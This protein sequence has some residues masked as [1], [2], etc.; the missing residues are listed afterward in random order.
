[1]RLTVCTPLVRSWFACAQSALLVACGWTESGTS[2]VSLA[3]DATF[4]T[5]FTSGRLA[6]QEWLSCREIDTTGLIPRSQCGGVHAPGTP[7]F[8]AYSRA[9][10]A[11]RRVAAVDSSAPTLHATA[12]IRLRAARG[13]RA[14]LDRAVEALEQ[15]RIRMP[16]DKAILNDLA[17][18]YEAVAERDQAIMPMLRALDAVDAALARDST[19]APARFNR[20]L[21]L[22]RLFLVRT[23]AP[24]W[25]AYIA[26]ERDERW[27]T[28]ARA[29]V[30]AVWQSQDS[31]AP[32]LFVQRARGRFFSLLGSWGAT[33]GRGD[34]SRGDRTLAEMVAL[35]DSLG[36][37][38]ADQSVAMTVDWLHAQLS[39]RVV[40]RRIAP[41]FVDLANGID[42]HDSS[43]YD[44]C[45]A[46]LGRA[47]AALRTMN[48][49]AARWAAVY[50]A[51]C[52]ANQRRF[53]AAADTRLE[54]ALA[55]ATAREPALIGKAL[56]LRGVIQMRRGNYETASQLYAEARS[57][58]ARAGDTFNEA[59]VS[60]LLTENLA[61]AGQSLGSEVEAYKG[62]GGL[63]PFRASRYLKNLLIQ[64][65]A[66]A[67]G[68]RLRAA[69][70]DVL[71]E[72]VIVDRALR[73]PGATAY[74]R[75]TRAEDLA[76]VGDTAKALADLDTAAAAA[77]LVPDTANRM[78]ATA[79][80]Q[81]ARARLI[82]FSNPRLTRR[83]VNQAVD[84][85]RAI[86][87]VNVLPAALFQSALL[88]NAQ[89]QGE[90]ARADLADAISVIEHA[91]EAFTSA[92][93]QAAYYETVEN[94]F[95]LAIQCELRDG[96]TDA[97]FDL[98]ERE[99]VAIRREA[100]SRGVGT[101][102]S[103]ASLSE[104]IPHDMLFVTY[105]VLADR[106]AIW[107]A[108]HG[109][110]GYRASM[111]ARDSVA[112]L[113]RRAVGEIRGS[114]TL[115][116]RTRLFEILLQP[117]TEELRGAHVIAAVP[118][119]ELVA[120]PLAALW[121]PVTKRYVVEDVALITEPS[122]SFM[123]AASR[124]S[125]SRPATL[126]ALV[127]GNPAHPSSSD[128]TLADLP[129]AAAEA[130]QVAD[131][132][133]RRKVLTGR[134]AT[135]RSVID[136]LSR[137]N[138]FHFAGHAV[139]DPGHPERSY[140]A[141]SDSGRARNGRLEAREIAH[142]SLSNTEIVVLSACRTLPAKPSRSGAV[143]GIAFSFLRAGAP[144][145]V[146]TLWDVADDGTADV[147][148]PLH[149]ALRD[150]VEPPEAL[151][152]AQVA[153]MKSTDRPGSPAGTWAAFVY[154]GPWT[155]KGRSR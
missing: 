34:R 73:A 144:A 101:S 17:V 97:A 15:A 49:P 105:A 121:N 71:S 90:R 100:R 70:L 88:A 150:G 52:E 18:A 91:R 63:A 92:Q 136:E 24:A 61:F 113:A 9:A 47:E 37:K 42:L 16:T 67:R 26:S 75:W 142:L 130:S 78:R 146:S 119:R 99:R 21:I 27:K 29:H 114:G 143:A 102:V 56:W 84:S 41:A 72:A 81:L 148:V 89:G 110:R 39:N 2:L 151:R 98:L 152:R 50:R 107:Y 106:V 30:Q 139:F 93:A 126:S 123:V 20:A 7:G 74:T 138:V 23:A 10:V 13:S 129:G 1:M 86:T 96:N 48:A 82:E 155:V 95:D 38:T 109:R 3:R 77:A 87:A 45:A 14:T 32:G 128:T 36:G 66:H 83:L 60:F 145:I 64:V 35:R 131:L 28:E 69:A 115:E 44:A 68:A 53:A 25:S 137:H 103:L 59:A 154:T 19:Y 65:A 117:L 141:L 125:R 79:D 58:F 108:R 55:E 153:A 133:P 140:L 80:V 43:A 22:E 122:A 120:V 135:R 111:V 85:Y 54:R 118:D 40:E 127:V 147:V 11:V 51:A 132:Y 5:R 149:R 31:R 8:A 6:E 94:V 124:V 57:Q 76:A 112:A 62:L 46:V 33:V 134:A 104:S 4:D 12:L 116:A